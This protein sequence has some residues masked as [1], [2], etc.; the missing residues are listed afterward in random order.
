MQRAPNLPLQKKRELALARSVG[1]SE[2]H[3]VQDQQAQK[4]GRERQTKHLCR[5]MLTCT[6]RLCGC[7]LTC[8]CHDSIPHTYQ[9]CHQE[10]YARVR[11]GGHAS[12]R[13]ERSTIVRLTKLYVSTI[14]EVGRWCRPA[15]GPSPLP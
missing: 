9:F 15:T 14:Q 6:E 8:I 2:R 3:T 5:P 11:R 7:A 12:I 4:N 13:R 1:T 10:G